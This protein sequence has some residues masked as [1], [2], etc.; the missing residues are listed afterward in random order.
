MYTHPNNNSN[1]NNGLLYTVSTD[2]YSNDVFVFNY[3]KS[4]VV[5]FLFPKGMEQF[6]R[7]VTNFTKGSLIANELSNNPY[8]NDELPINDTLLSIIVSED[9]GYS[10]GNFLSSIEYG[11]QFYD[12]TEM[13]KIMHDNL[14]ILAYTG[15]MSKYNV[16][17]S[18]KN[19]SSKLYVKSLLDHM[20]AKF[21]MNKYFAINSNH[22]IKFIIDDHLIEFIQLLY[23]DLDREDIN[24]RL[25]KM[26]DGNVWEEI[27]KATGKPKFYSAIDTFPMINIES[28]DL[29][30]DNTATITFGLSL[31]TPTQIV[32]DSDIS[33]SNLPLVNIRPEAILLTDV[34]D[35]LGEEDTI[36]ALN[37]DISFIERNRSYYNFTDQDILD[38]K[39]GILKPYID[40]TTLTTQEISYIGLYNS[41]LSFIKDMKIRIEGSINDNIIANSRNSATSKTIG[42]DNYTKIKQIIIIPYFVN[43][44]PSRLNIGDDVVLYN[45]IMNRPN[46]ILEIY[47]N[48]SILTEGQDYNLILNDDDTLDIDFGSKLDKL[49]GSIISLS[50][51]KKEV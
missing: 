6:N 21:Y 32:V 38:M 33:I 16:T 17:L 41:S 34:L 4:I 36:K 46:I 22:H 45:Y 9:Y 13:H 15:N 7:V 39:S 29:Q 11:N 8:E 3:I 1:N 47:S 24:A 50:L 5:P 18:V 19:V 25:L 14:F 48:N 31:F 35:T 26:T 30:D 42:A 2:V 27:D 44:S 37:F 12:T 28:L 20:K 40:I 10:E 51:Y 43:G 49:Y 23:G